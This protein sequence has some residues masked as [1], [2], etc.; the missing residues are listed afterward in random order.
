MCSA[1]TQARVCVSGTELNPSERDDT[2]RKRA[3]ERKKDTERKLL[4]ELRPKEESGAESRGA[5]VRLTTGDWKLAGVLWQKAHRGKDLICLREWRCQYC[6]W[7]QLEQL[8]ELEG[9]V[10]NTSSLQTEATAVLWHI[11]HT[12]E[13]GPSGLGPPGDFGEAFGLRSEMSQRRHRK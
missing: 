3:K 5:C 6:C 12:F 8:E 2:E 4:K 1:H 13:A 11:R 7:W 10:F 9:V